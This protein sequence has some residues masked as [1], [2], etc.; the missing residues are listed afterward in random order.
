M[1]CSIT[2]QP[3]FSPLFSGRFNSNLTEA[4]APPSPDR[5]LKAPLSWK[6]NLKSTGAC[7][8][9]FLLSFAS[10]HLIYQCASPLKFPPS[11]WDVKDALLEEE[12]GAA[13]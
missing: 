10:A 3:R 4:L 9:G 2:F 8:Q 13:F 6:T 12:E 7:G 5:M 1:V 11:L